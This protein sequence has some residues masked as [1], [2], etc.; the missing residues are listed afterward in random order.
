MSRKIMVVLAVLVAV[1]AVGKYLQTDVATP[2][3]DVEEALPPQQAPQP[4][5]RDEPTAAADDEAVAVEQP[6]LPALVDSDEPAREA[7]GELSQKLVA[8]L[9]PQEQVRKWVVAIDLAADG[10]LPGKN[11]PLAYPVG[12]FKVTGSEGDYRPD[13]ANHGR[14]TELVDTLTAIPP[15]RAAAFYRHW[16]PLFDEAYRELGKPGSFDAR[17]RQAIERAI[18]VEPLRGEPVLV[19]PSVFYRYA[20]PQLERASDIEKLLWRM[21]PDNGAKL[22]RWLAEFRDAL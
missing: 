1:L 7:A 12:A 15:A 22:Q 19:R 17:L 20:D 8:W 5:V 16:Q 10:A 21:G 14:T 18:A 9:T 2:P 13:P 11:R 6:P 4:V 3:P